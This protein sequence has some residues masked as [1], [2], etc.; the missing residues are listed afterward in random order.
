MIFINIK[1]NVPFKKEDIMKLKS[2]DIIQIT[3]TIYTARDAAHKKMLEEFDK[4]IALPFDVKGQTIYFAGPTPAKPGEIIGSA[5]PTTSS[6][7][8][9]YSPKMI[10]FGINALIGKG[11]IDENVINAIK[12]YKA[13]YIGAVGGAGALISEHI[14]SC[15]VIAYSELG[16]EAIHKLYVEDFPAIVIIDCEGNNLYKSERLKYKEILDV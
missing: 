7:M 4:K 11:E 6:R 3:G 9:K 5:G 8:N 12:K 1:L 10:E 13:V 16:S 15:E 2:G 14:K